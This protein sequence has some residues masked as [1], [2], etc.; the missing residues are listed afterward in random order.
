ML[1]LNR[2][3]SRAY[4]PQQLILNSG[5]HFSHYMVA[6]MMMLPAT[7][8]LALWN[9]C[10][11]DRPHTVQHLSQL[12]ILQYD[13]CQN[14][15]LIHHFIANVPQLKCL[16]FRAHFQLLQSIFQGSH[17]QLLFL[18]SREYAYHHEP[19]L[20]SLHV[21]YNKLAL[22][23]LFLDLTELCSIAHIKVFLTCSP[24]GT[25]QILI[26]NSAPSV[27]LQGHSH[28]LWMDP[29]LVTTS[30]SSFYQSY[31]TLPNCMN[32]STLGF[33]VHHQLP[34]LVQS[35]VHIVDDAI[36]KSHPLL[37]PSFAAFSLTQHQDLFQRVSS[38]NQVAKIL[39]F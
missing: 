23:I 2:L 30:F 8:K 20:W 22:R 32:F 38:S 12:L 24:S 13:A 36:Q 9:S 18:V 31:P 15:I 29:G 5:A 11:A 7:T 39:E 37:A 35:H 28:E 19:T 1:S 10:S 3:H 27:P 16:H 26:L 6:I 14:P 34:E 4:A 21:G 25:S 33:P 17:W